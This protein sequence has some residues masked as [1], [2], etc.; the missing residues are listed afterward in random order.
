MKTKLFFLSVFTLVMLAC[1]NRSGDYQSLQAER[2]SLAREKETMK[3]E[4]ESYF[5]TIN[6]IEQNI[7]KIKN[8]E[9][10]ISL[11]PLG[12]ES[13]VDSRNKI[14][15]DLTFINEMLKANREEINQLKSKLNKSNYKFA[16]LERTVIRLTKA[17]EEEALKIKALEEQLAM[18]DSLITQLN[19]NIEDL[20]G[21]IENLETEKEKHISRIKEQDETIHTAWY[22]F[23]TRKELKE[24]NIITSEG[25]FRPD[26]VLESD[27]NKS[28]FVRID[29]RKTKS[30]PLYSSRAKILST[31]PKTSYT[32]EKEND[33][34]TLLIT[35]TREFWSVSKYLVIEVD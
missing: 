27:F 29:A 31:H 5:A 7:E 28:Y 6:L 8:A 1:N 4:M 15:D 21:N 32:L 16:E 30:I 33:T 2:D 24:Q 25:W 3:T 9:K 23:G 19:V 20:T 34:F 10:L 12:E 22:V 18:K 13:D 17:L 26:R 14:N 35:D 11:Q